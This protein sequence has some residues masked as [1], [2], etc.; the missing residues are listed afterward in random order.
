MR[1]RVWAPRARRVQVGVG[2]PER[3]QLR[4]LTR[5]DGGWWHDDRDLPHGTDYA[6]HLD[7]GPARPDPRS[8]WQPNGVHGPSR[9]FDA[10]AFAWT[11]AGWAGVDV[12]GRVLYELHVGTFTPE[13][14]LDAAVQHLEELVSLGVDVV[15][16]MPLAPFDGDRGWGYDGVGPYAVHQAYGGP[17]A[18]QRFVDAAHAHGIGVCLDVV[19][20][21]LGP[22]GAYVGE[23]GPYWTDAHHTPW[24]AA[25]NLDQ[26]GSREVRAWVVDS[27]LRWL[28]DFH[29]DA[30]RL[31]AVHELRDDS[32]RPL[33]AELSDEVA[34]LATELGRPLSLVAE[35]D[36]NDV[37]AITPTS[38]GGW[39]MTAQWADDVHHAVHALVTGERQGYYVDFGS[40][41]TLRHALTRVFVHD[42]GFSTFRGRPWGRPVPEHTDGHR[43][44]VAAQNHDQVGNR[45]LGDRPAQRLAPGQLAAEAA[46]V[47]LSPFTPMLFMGE[48]WGTR[49]PFPF[50]SSY[51]EPE[52]AAAV[53]EGRQREFAGHG[54]AQLYGE[55]VV[56]VPDPQDPATRD[57]AV[58]DRTE[59]V[60]GEHAHLLDWYRTL[61]ALRRAVPD[62]GSGDLASTAVDIH[63]ASDTPAAGDAAWGDQPTAR[64]PAGGT[65]AGGTSA[66]GTSGDLTSSDGPPT[67]GPPTGT[68][69]GPWQGALVVHRGDARVVVNLARTA[70]QVPVPVPGPVQV[71]AAW[72]GGV[73]R[74]A[75]PGEPVVVE[76]P[77]H[78]VVVLGPAA[79]GDTD[80]L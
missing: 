70:A 18:L 63:P 73:L 77:G 44:V 26:P 74:P 36:L 45:A 78:A 35:T 62:L 10:A 58:L 57:A 23:Y 33:L 67:D 56:H 7:G 66:G 61:V 47:L 32:P 11:D 16:L 72:T 30:L 43:F 4:E 55:Q 21:H 2:P 34:A 14:T 49:R 51:T 41:Q 29:V 37:V 64:T 5:E 79:G 54:S 13:G 8:A 17:A 19:H 68:D 80:D 39:G 27:A 48:E 1:V 59:R 15:E 75:S 40:P 52:L 20:N 69:D 9:V 31:D 46:L 65:S 12:R 22:V 3:A 24:G 71:L 60:R 50:F 38:E 28:R 25:I 53:R 76:V 6:F 42:G